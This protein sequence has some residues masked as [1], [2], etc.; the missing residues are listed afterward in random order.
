MDNP[1]RAMAFLCKPPH[2]ITDIEAQIGASQEL[3]TNPAVVELTTRL[4]Y[5]PETKK[6]KP[7]AGG[8][9]PGSPRRLVAVLGQLDLTWDLYASTSDELLKLL[10]KEFNKFEGR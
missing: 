1:E 7:G 4:Y 5:D 3:V 2:I 6:T 8:K 9:G 10:P